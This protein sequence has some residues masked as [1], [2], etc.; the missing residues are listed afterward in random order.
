[1]ELDFPQLYRA[2]DVEDKLSLYCGRV[3]VVLYH[4]SI[5]FSCKNRRN[6]VASDIHRIL[7]R[8]VCPHGCQTLLCVRVLL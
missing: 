3:G 7:A 4:G 2:F 8:L 5:C 6:S 1:M